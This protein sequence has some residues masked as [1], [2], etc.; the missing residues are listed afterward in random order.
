MSSTMI[1]KEYSNG[2]SI[3]LAGVVLN[4]KGVIRAEP[5]SGE[6]CSADVT[7]GPFV[8]NSISKKA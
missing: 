6:I 2:P 4:V 5:F 8:S 1:P 3:S 7:G